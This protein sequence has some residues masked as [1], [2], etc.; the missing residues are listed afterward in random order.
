MVEM[1]RRHNDVNVLCLPG[2][3]IGERSIDELVLRWLQTDFDGGRHTGRLEKIDRIEKQNACDR[4]PCEDD[5]L[6]DRTAATDS[7]AT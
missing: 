3:L 6:R 1:S 2:D 5:T 4:S 7:S